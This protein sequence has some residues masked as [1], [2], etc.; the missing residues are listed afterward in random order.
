MAADEWFAKKMDLTR[1]VRAI[2]V[3]HHI[4]LE[5]VGIN[6]HPSHVWLRGELVRRAGEGSSLSS[7][8]VQNLLHDILHIQGIVRVDFDLVN[9]EKT[10]SG[11]VREKD[12]ENGK[13]KRS[14]GKHR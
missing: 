9:W 7:E 1:K 4:D 6:V 11:A 12:S 14:P 13:R 10:H 3:E 2:L 5:K 8:T